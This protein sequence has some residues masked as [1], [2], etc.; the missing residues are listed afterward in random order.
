MP[1]PPFFSFAHVV[2]IELL[3]LIDQHTPEHTFGSIPL[4]HRTWHLSGGTPSHGE[5]VNSS[6]LTEAIFSLK[7]LLMERV[8]LLGPKEK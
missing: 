8:Q 2:D 1:P 3:P 4:T 5:N 6:A 7:S